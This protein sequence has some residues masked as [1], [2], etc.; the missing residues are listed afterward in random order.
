MQCVISV[1]ISERMFKPKIIIIIY[2]ETFEV[3]VKTNS[4]C[5]VLEILA[6]H[7]RLLY[8]NHVT[9]TIATKTLQ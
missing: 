7:D 6:E 1:D 9:V 5:K 3:S 8:N 4:V 2:F